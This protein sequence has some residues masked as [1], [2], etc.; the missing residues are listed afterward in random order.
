[1]PGKTHDLGSSLW[2]EEE[3]SD[4]KRRQENEADNSRHDGAGPEEPARS[5][6]ERLKWRPHAV[7][8]NR[9]CISSANVLSRN[10]L[11][12]AA[13]RIAHS[14]PSLWVLHG[15]FEVVR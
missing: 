4:E 9:L 15:V 1:M 3:R 7:K 12:V 11:S 14:C 2:A 10:V 8:V 5:A 6:G 13:I